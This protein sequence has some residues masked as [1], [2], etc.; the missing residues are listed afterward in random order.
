MTSGLRHPRRP[1]SVAL[2]CLRLLLVLP[3]TAS[4]AENASLPNA[5]TAGY[6]LGRYTIDSGGSGASG[7]GF[8]IRGT[9]G[10]PDANASGPATGGHYELSGGHWSADS[11][12]RLFADGFESR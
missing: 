8:A 5:V 1:R 2:R 9:I 6:R 11:N 7:G 4:G 3:L 10:Q 12:D